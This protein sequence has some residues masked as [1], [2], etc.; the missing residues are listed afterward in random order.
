MVQLE[1]IKT[2]TQYKGQSTMTNPATMPRPDTAPLDH[3]ARLT[4][5]QRRF[6]DQYLIHRNGALAAR[7]AGYAPTHSNRIAT[8]LLSLV[9]VKQAM[10]QRLSVIQASEGITEDWIRKQIQSIALDGKNDSDRLRA[11]E[12]L[13]KDKGMFKDKLE[14]SAIN[15]F[16]IIDS[17]RQ[18]KTLTSAS[19]NKAI[20]EQSN[21]VSL[22]PQD[23]TPIQSS[24]DTN[25]DEAS[26]ASVGLF[27]SYEAMD[28]PQG[29]ED[30]N[31]TPSE[32]CEV[33]LNSIDTCKEIANG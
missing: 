13:G 21:A 8:K 23:P 33:N 7:E 1:Y 26:S 19:N 29:V 6:V 2:P 9:H 10:E 17:A 18:V 5:L 32:N 27:K 3:C 20:E 14:T 15:L 30:V 16:N 22:A 25:I 12:L 11:L 4:P 24:T 31:I 28:T